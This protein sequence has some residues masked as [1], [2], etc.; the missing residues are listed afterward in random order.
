M[1]D[2]SVNWP[3]IER[4]RSHS[5]T[6]GKR[7]RKT[8]VSTSSVRPSVQ[9]SSQTLTIDALHSSFL[10]TKTKLD[11]QVARLIFGANLPLSTVDHPEFRKLIKMMKPTY[12]PPTRK[13]LST[14]ILDTVYDEVMSESSKC[15]DGKLVTV[16][17][18]GWTGPQ[19]N[20]VISHSLSI[21]CKKT[22]FMNAIS[23]TNE[24]KT[25]PYCLD[26]LEKAIVEAEKTFQCRVIGIVT[27]NTNSMVSMRSKIQ[28]KNPDLFAYGC[29]THLMN[30]VGKA[31]SKGEPMEDVKRIQHF[32]KDH[33]FPRET[34]KKTGVPQ[35][36]LPNETRWNSQYACLKNFLKNHSSY[37]NLSKLPNADV[38]SSILQK[39][40]DFQ[41]YQDVQNL[42]NNLRPV[43]KALKWVRY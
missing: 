4:L 35:P 36:I 5:Q 3:K 8:P 10:N 30:L 32:F 1:C 11:L 41:L 13:T 18:D 38:P 7:K 31:C 23:A 22:H 21:E 2:Y 28:E 12:I 33:T 6:C 25:T 24:K 42:V 40:M 15:L 19:S 37:L 39:L 9:G 29:N 34:L 27:D 26:L 20:P 43:A 17:Q 14:T 16:M